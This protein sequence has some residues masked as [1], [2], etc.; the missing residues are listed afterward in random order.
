MNQLAMQSPI[1]AKGI[2]IIPFGNGA[3]RV[4]ENKEVNCSIHG[5][6]FN[7]HDKKDILRA[8]QEGIV[9]SYEYGL[10]I[11]RKMG[12]NIQ[13]IRAGF[14]NMF[15]SPIFTQTLASVS[16]AVIE[17]FDTAGAAGAARAAGMGIGIYQSNDEAFASLEKIAVVEPDTRNKSA[18]RNAYTNW[19][20]LID[21]N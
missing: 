13:V 7:I 1:G 2:S 21:E 20:K 17:L 8:G 3:E 14:A 16:G 10:E 19:R 6:N 15:L 9:F 5:I 11:M 18:Y 12:M 4:L